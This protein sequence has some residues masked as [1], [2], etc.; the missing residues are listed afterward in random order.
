MNTLMQVETATCSTRGKRKRN[1]DYVLF[2][3]RTGG[4]VADGVGG[5]PLGDAIARYACHIAQ[6]ELDNGS[7]AKDAAASARMAAERFID[8]VDAE[9]SGASLL[10]YRL[11]ENG[12]DLAG[13]GNVACM[14]IPP[15]RRSSQQDS[16]EDMLPDLCTNTARV[17]T[18]RSYDNPIGANDEGLTDQVRSG[19]ED[20][21]PLLGHRSPECV[22]SERDTPSPPIGSAGSNQLPH[23][24]H[25]EEIG[26]L[27]LC[28]DGV[29]KEIARSEVARILMEARS[30]REA[31]AMLTLGHQAQDNATAL[32]MFGEDDPCNR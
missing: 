30:P 31:A 11:R 13:Y 16:V 32:V 25:F 19:N 4:C 28:T 1:E 24:Y 5:A 21:R 26:R 22:P 3:P 14:S 27:A 7:S 9:G 29:W 17:G 23:F 8:I 10:V 18:H 12:I 6:H 15:A 2:E 20:N